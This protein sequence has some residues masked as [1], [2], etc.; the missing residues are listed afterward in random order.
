MPAPL[1][2]RYVRE[3]WDYKKA[4][5]ENIKKAISNFDWNKA[6]ENFSIDEKVELLK[7]KFSEIT[8]QIKKINLSINNLH[9]WQT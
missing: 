4:N 2:P 7:L 5:I 9:E 3:V 6:L 1:P 8:F